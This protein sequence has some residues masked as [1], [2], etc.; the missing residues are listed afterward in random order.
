MSGSN[1][2]GTGSVAGGLPRRKAFRSGGRDTV[3]E[4]L[5]GAAVVYAAASVN[6]AIL[7]LTVLGKGIH[8]AASAGMREP[9]KLYRMAAPS[10]RRWSCLWTWD[11]P[12]PRRSLARSFCLRIRSL[13]GLR[14]WRETVSL[15]S[16][17]PGRKGCGRL[18]GFAGAL[19]PW[20]AVLAAALWLVVFSVSSGAL[21][22][23]LLHDRRPRGGRGT[24]FRGV[25]GC[26]RRGGGNGIADSGGPPAEHPGD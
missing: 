5:L 10:G 1:G 9:R 13:A 24:G 4:C 3:T 12:W 22:G 8:G 16:W 25:G 15:F 14:W 26:S 7:I 17:L 21:R 6:F 19:A 18:L 11:G 2:T 23:L 20:A